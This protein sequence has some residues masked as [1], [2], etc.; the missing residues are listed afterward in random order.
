M[1]RIFGREIIDN[2]EQMG[3]L[4]ARAQLGVTVLM[5]VSASVCRRGVPYYWKCK[6]KHAV[7]FARGFVLFLEIM[8]AKDAEGLPHI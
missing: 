8:F 5:G 1:N 2:I 4:S 7:L 6:I 3:V